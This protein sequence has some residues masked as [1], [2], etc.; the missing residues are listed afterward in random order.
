MPDVTRL[1]GLSKASILMLACVHAGRMHTP[2]KLLAILGDL[3]SD[4]VIGVKPPGKAGQ[5]LPG[6]A[7]R[8]VVDPGLHG[9]PPPSVEGAAPI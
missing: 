2:C 6:T 7:E 5:I 4:V 3:A 8:N 1:S 9:I